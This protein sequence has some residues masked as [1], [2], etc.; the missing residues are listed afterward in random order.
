V[1]QAALAEEAERLGV[2][3]EQ[4]CLMG[5]NVLGEAVLSIIHALPTQPDHEVSLSDVLLQHERRLNV[6]W[7]LYTGP[8]WHLAYLEDLDVLPSKLATLEIA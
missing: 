5:V 3:I 4:F 8:W 2:D 1:F 7:A 6:D